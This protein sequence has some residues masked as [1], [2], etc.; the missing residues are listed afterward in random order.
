MPPQYTLAL[1]YLMDVLKFYQDLNEYAA[2]SMLQEEKITVVQILILKYK[3][4]FSFYS[5]DYLMKCK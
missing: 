1:G 5:V 2:K 3:F 4:G